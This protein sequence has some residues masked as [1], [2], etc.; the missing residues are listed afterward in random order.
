[1]E[2]MHCDRYNDQFSESD[3][4]LHFTDDHHVLHCLSHL[5]KPIII[6][7]LQQYNI[8]NFNFF[9][10]DKLYPYKFQLAVPSKS[11]MCG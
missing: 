1:M 7:K 10:C 6:D 4:C 2:L 5:V 3:N 9:R 11:N 8:L